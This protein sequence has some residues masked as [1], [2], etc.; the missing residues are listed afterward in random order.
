MAG[1]FARPRH[2]VPDHPAPAHPVPAIPSPPVPP[3]FRLAPRLRACDSAGRK[4]EDFVTDRIALG[5]GLIVLGIFLADRIWFGGGL[6]VLL[7]RKLLALSEYIAF[8]R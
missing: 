3:G 6:P 8:W 2:P 1:R 4:R 5:L 7:G